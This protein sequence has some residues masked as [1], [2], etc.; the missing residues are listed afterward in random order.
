MA[1]PLVDAVAVTEAGRL[2]DVRLALAGGKT[3]S[4]AGRRGPAAEAEQAEAVIE[5]CGATGLPVFLGAGLGVGIA[6]CRAAGLPVAVVDR[7]EAIAAA[8][9]VR[10]ALEADAQTGDVRFF[11]A[12]GLAEVADAVRAFAKSRGRSELH[13]VAQA[14]Y[15]RLDPD[16]YGRLATRLS[17]PA[18]PSRPLFR[19][20]LPRVLCLTSKLFLVGEVTRA[21][22]RL[23]APCR[24]LETGETPLDRETYVALVREALDGFAP[25]F[26]LTI[27]HLGLDREGVLLDLLERA[28]IPLASWFVDSPELILPLYLPAVSASTVLFTWD[29]DTVEPLKARGCPQVHSLPLATD[30]TRFAPPAVLPDTHPWRARVSFVGN[31]MLGKTAS[32]LALADPPSRLGAAFAAVA[33]GFA[34]APERLVADYLARARPEL[35]ADYLSIPTVARR[36]AFETAVIWECTRRDRAQRIAGLLPFAPTI[37]GDDGWLATLPGEGTAWRRLPELAYYDELP[38][39]YP[40][41]DVNSNVTSAQMKGAVNQRVFDVPACGAFVLT[42]ARRQLEDLFEPGR[43]MAVYRTAEELVELTGRYLADAA[44][45]RTLAEAGRRRVL[46]EHTYPRRLQTLFAVMRQSFGN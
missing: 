31:S 39:F 8:T 32:R 1:G 46:A 26:V 40:L 43:E 20:A 45:R 36:L 11:D 42:D 5:R 37:V 14:V 44:A 6:R 3:W 30:E 25:D 13:L 27:N 41:S 33:D 4:L 28:G 29:A 12:P 9:R 7:E 23:G 24:Y 22:E 18:I 38:R 10:E 34:K 16:Y 2:V 35:F 21:C 17:R 19:Q 15:R